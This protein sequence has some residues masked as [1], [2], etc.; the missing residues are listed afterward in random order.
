MT[1]QLFDALTVRGERTL[2][3]AQERSHVASRAVRPGPLVEA[4]RDGWP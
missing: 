1:T 3:S 2:L 4:R